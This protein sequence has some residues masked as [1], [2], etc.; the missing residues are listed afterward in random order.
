MTRRIITLFLVAVIGVSVAEAQHVSRDVPYDTTHQRQVLDIYAPAAAKNL[1]V[2]F[3][4]HGG[5]WQTG[6]K[7]MVALKPKAFMDG[8][9]VFVS[10]NHRLLPTV[11]MGAI[12]HD[13]ST[14]L[15]WVH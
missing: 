11:D 15:G 10:I 5:G 13:V 3:W 14:A 9:F 2:V 8:G 12:T 4:I 7:T 6:E 1:P